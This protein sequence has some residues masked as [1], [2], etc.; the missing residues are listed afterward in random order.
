MG[1]EL[2]SNKKIAETS[3]KGNQEKWFNKDSNQW[4]KIDQFGYEALSEVVVS[5][6]LGYSNIEDELGFT[7][8]KYS[9]G[10]YK[11]HNHERIGCVSEN[12]IANGDESIITLSKLFR[13]KF[14]ESLSSLMGKLSS[15]KKRIEWLARTTAEITGLE[16]FPEY[17]TLLFEIDSAFLN[18]D[19]HLNNI[20][21]IRKGERFDYCPIFDNGAS[22]LSNVL[23]YRLDIDTK[24]HLKTVVARPFNTTFNRQ[25]NAARGL[26]G[27]QLK[28]EEL[29]KDTVKDIISNE[30]QM[31]PKRDRELIASRVSG[32]IQS[33]VLIG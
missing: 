25:V 19:R 7:Y 31:Y 27:S 6:V 28:F 18:E 13:L 1:I 16:R 10:K 4:V 32:I 29:T 11:V 21:V 22:L 20:A 3:S 12:F 26:F 30:V 23:N 24:A 17:L 14:G 33:R 2:V 15:D 9:M 8:V 5:R